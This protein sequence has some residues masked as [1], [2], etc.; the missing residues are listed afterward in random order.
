MFLTRRHLAHTHTRFNRS[1]W[2]PSIISSVFACRSP[3]FVCFGTVATHLHRELQLY[4]GADACRLI[5]GWRGSVFFVCHLFFFCFVSTKSLPAGRKIAPSQEWLR[6][7]RGANKTGTTTATTTTTTT[8]AKT[9]KNGRRWVQCIIGQSTF[10]GV[11]RIVV[12]PCF[13][14]LILGLLGR[15]CFPFPP[16]P[17]HPNVALSRVQQ[18]LFVVVHRAQHCLPLYRRGAQKSKRKL[19]PQLLCSALLVDAFVLLVLWSVR[20]DDARRK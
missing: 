2:S 5:E 8:T 6:S 7:G 16:S 13:C 12:V 18:T 14:A 4:G 10:S 20:L 17:H 3:V 19:V 11:L 9:A 15:D 1:F